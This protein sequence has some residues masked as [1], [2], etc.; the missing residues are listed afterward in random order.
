MLIGVGV[1][2]TTHTEIE[3]SETDGDITTDGIMGITM[4]GIIIMAFTIH[5]G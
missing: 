3:D 2:I 5:F 4:D 1:I